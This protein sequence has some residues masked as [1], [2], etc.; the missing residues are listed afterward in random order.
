MKYVARVLFFGALVLVASQVLLVAQAKE[1]EEKKS[2]DIVEI[3]VQVETLADGLTVFGPAMAVR[4]AASAKIR[5]SESF[6]R[7]V[8]ADSTGPVYSAGNKEGDDICACPVD[9]GTCVC[10]L[11]PGILAGFRSP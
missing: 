10:K 8:A 7:Q 11:S 9:Y 5:V 4:E 2:E 1:A 3:D 6:L